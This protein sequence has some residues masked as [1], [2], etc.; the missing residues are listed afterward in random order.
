MHYITRKD[1]VTALANLK[2]GAA[3]AQAIRVLTAYVDFHT[4]KPEVEEMVF[5]CKVRLLTP[6]KNPCYGRD[7]MTVGTVYTAIAAAGCCITTT[8]DTQHTFMCHPSHFEVVP[9]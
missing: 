7:H 9:D 4:P 8:T 2:D 5:P 3:N 6:F 1:A